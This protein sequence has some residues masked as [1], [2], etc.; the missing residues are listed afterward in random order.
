MACTDNT[1]V[2]QIIKGDMRYV[3]MELDDPAGNSYVQV[4]RVGAWRVHGVCMVFA[5]CLHGVCMVGA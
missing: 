5:W 3:H 1:D 2:L 4:P